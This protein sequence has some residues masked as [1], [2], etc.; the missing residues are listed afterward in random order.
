MASIL[1]RFQSP[2]FINVGT[3]KT[4]VYGARVD[5]EEALQ[6]RT[7]DACNPIHNYPGMFP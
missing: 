3:H 5:N 7:V 4:L 6:Q 1:A 2:E